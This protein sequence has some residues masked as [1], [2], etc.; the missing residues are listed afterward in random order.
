MDPFLFVGYRVDCTGDVDGWEIMDEVPS[1]FPPGTSGVYDWSFWPHIDSSK[2]SYLYFAKEFFY[3]CPFGQQEL[4]NHLD[5]ETK[6][7]P[8]N[9]NEII[10]EIKNSPAY[11][12]LEK[13]YDKAEIK[14]GIFKGQ[15]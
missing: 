3:A 11:K 5:E 8:D 6:D 7:L 1:C 14:Y 2:D 4:W 12:K 15:S 10:E 9:H 13:L